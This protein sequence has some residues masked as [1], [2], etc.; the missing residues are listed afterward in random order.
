M[1]QVK[2]RYEFL[3]DAEKNRKTGGGLQRAHQ[4]QDGRDKRDKTLQRNLET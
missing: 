4:N 2:I 3:N 1:K